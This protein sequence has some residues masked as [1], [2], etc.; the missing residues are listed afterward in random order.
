LTFNIARIQWKLRFFGSA[1]GYVWQLMRPLLL[2][3]VLYVFFTQIGHVGQGKDS[4][5]GQPDYLYGVQ[6]LGS[7]VLFTFF[8]ES[9]G[10]AVTSVVSQ[11]AVVRKIQ[12]PRMVIPLSIVLGAMFNLGLN[13]IVVL[14]FALASGVRPLATWVE[15][16]VII[17][18]LTVFAT[19]LAMLLA[20]MYVYFRDVAP[21]WD[22][23]SQILFY[24]SP[25]IVPLSSVQAKLSP[26]LVKIYM[27]N[28]LAAVFQQFRH[29]M[30]NNAT[31]SVET[32]LGPVGILGVLV[33]VAAVFVLGFTVFNRTA[34]YVAENL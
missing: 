14:I 10:G 2:F 15:L 4:A 5:P 26:L 34:P 13:L 28:P 12:F 29:A 17:A 32:L 30:I 16:P 31:P 8:S 19:G 22:V 9:T 3:G 27:L 33:I 20:S 24:A 21:I 23:L 18:V 7:I 25:V 1:L 11:E 6:M